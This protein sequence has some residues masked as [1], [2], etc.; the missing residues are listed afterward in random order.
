MVL[1]ELRDGAALPGQVDHVQVI[2]VAVG[3]GP[4]GID[5]LAQGRVEQGALQIVGG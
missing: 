5:I 1:D 4:L 3:L 2:V